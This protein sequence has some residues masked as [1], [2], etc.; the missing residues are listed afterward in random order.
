MP[1]LP[2][3]HYFKH[4][5]FVE[6]RNGSQEHNH[7]TIFSPELLDEH[8]VIIVNGEY[9]KITDVHEDTL[10]VESI[11]DIAKTVYKVI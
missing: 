11:T 6:K 5:V 9:F 3:N 4:N 10:T 8:D 2:A 7:F 1:H